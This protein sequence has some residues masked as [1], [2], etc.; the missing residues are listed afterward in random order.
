MVSI[1][2]TFVNV[3]LWTPTRKKVLWD[4]SA[5]GVTDLRVIRDGSEEMAAKETNDRAGCAENDAQL[6][7]QELAKLQAEKV[8]I[9]VQ[10]KQCTETITLIETKLQ[11]AEENVRCHCCCS[12]L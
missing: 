12:L 4:L 2:E 10:H 9:T 7:K 5:L 1:R 11:Q 3:K 6:L 8:A